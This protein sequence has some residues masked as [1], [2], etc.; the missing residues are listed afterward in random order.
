MR[1]KEHNTWKMGLRRQINHKSKNW[2]SFQYCT[3]HSQLGER[4]PM[5]SMKLHCLNKVKYR[6]Y[7]LCPTKWTCIFRTLLFRTSFAVPSAFVLSHVCRSEDPNNTYTKQTLNNTAEDIQ[8][9]AFHSASVLWDKKQ[10]RNVN[11]TSVDVRMS[12]IKQKV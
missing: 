10:K 4:D 12:N 1:E 5:K 7:V 3:C 6:S 8:S 9:T 2:K 11:C